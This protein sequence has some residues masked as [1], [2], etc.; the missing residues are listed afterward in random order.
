MDW[1]SGFVRNK[2]VW[3]L[4][5][6]CI[7]LLVG[8]FIPLA[9]V[10]QWSSS[11]AQYKLVLGPGA[12]R[13]IMV[14]TFQL[15]IIVAALSVILAY[16]VAYYLSICSPRKQKLLLILVLTPLWVS[17]LIR[18]YGWIVVLGRSGVVNSLLL[19][20]GL[21]EQPL[22]LLYTRFAVY[23]AMIQVLLPIAV[24][25]LFSAM[26]SINDAYMKAARILGATW[27]DSFRYVF[28]PLTANAV[29]SSAILIFILS[30]GFFIT[31]ALVGGPKDILV[32]NI[33]QTQVN[34]AMNWEL[35][36]VLGVVLLVA[37][38]LVVAAVTVLM[39]KYSSQ[40]AVGGI[41]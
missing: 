11:I 7:L 14:T 20:I 2:Y 18:T 41:K 9:Q 30:L 19:D 24:L 3:L 28:L 10:A 4:A 35:A 26:V 29:A 38:G 13:D 6:A 37:G 36:A 1:I 22:Q 40:S 8:F 16:P 34:E 27:L 39:G 5:P 12:Y 15:S 32:S 21:V 33:I 31:P 23:V 17:V 25:M